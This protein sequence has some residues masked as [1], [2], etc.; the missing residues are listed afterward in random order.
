MAVGAENCVN[1]LLWKLPS[2]NNTLETSPITLENERS[3]CTELGGPIRGAQPQHGCPPCGFALSV[4][5]F[6]PKCQRQLLAEF[7]FKEKGVG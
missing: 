7:L 5:S 6:V 1:F 4:I 2:K 3:F